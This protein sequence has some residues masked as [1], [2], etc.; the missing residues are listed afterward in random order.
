MQSIMSEK[1]PYERYLVGGHL[2]VHFWTAGTERAVLKIVSE[3]DQNWLA[4]LCQ[5]Q[6]LRVT[7]SSSHLQVTLELLVSPSTTETTAIAAIQRLRRSF[8]QRYRPLQIELMGAEWQPPLSEY[9][10]RLD[11]ADS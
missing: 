9:L 3:W 10:Y 7:E 1:T 6:F 4:E 2:F 5:V 8:V 11:V